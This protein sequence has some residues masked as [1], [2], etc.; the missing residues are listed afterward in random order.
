M[1]GFIHVELDMDMIDPQIQSFHIAGIEEVTLL[2]PENTITELAAKKFGV[3][4][5]RVAAN[6]VSE[7]IPEL[8]RKFPD[9]ELVVAGNGI[10]LTRG[11]KFYPRAKIGKFFSMFDSKEN[12]TCDW[13]QF[14]ELPV[15]MINPIFK[16][17]YNGII[18]ARPT[19][20]KGTAF[21]NII[22]TLRSSNIQQDNI[23][24]KANRFTKALR[25]WQSEGRPIR[26]EEEQRK[27]F[28]EICTPCQ[29]FTKNNRCE[30][31][32]CALKHKIS[33]QTEHCPIGKW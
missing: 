15:D 6:Q 8:V 18:N 9:E 27:I 7:I 23:L 10:F 17:H 2:Q 21:K 24:I 3:N 30:L 16:Y 22:N 11:F 4:S 13:N 5:L 31:C 1:K 32:G 29:H 14:E 19:N 20:Y 25:G 28:D 33:F 12:T 26:N